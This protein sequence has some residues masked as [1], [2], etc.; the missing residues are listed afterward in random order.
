MTTKNNKPTEANTTPGLKEKVQ[1]FRDKAREVLRMKLISA[2]LQDLFFEEKYIK[3]A[4]KNV[5]DV[6]LATARA[7]YHLENLDESDPD[8]ETKKKDS[9]AVLERAVSYEAEAIKN[10]NDNIALANKA[11][12]R[13]NRNI[14]EIEEGKVK[15]SI[16]E[17]KNLADR[18]IESS[19]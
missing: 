16:D 19:L 11:M 4:E 8:Y 15:V 7:K 17:V 6:K 2:L 3:N 13:I 12:E 1:S 18:M 5:V 9:E 10:A 14:S